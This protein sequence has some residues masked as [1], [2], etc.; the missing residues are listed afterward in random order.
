MN[1]RML[2]KECV[3]KYWDDIQTRMLPS[4]TQSYKSRLA[5][6]YNSPLANIKMAEFKGIKVVEWLNWLKQQPTAKNKSRKSF[7][8]DLDF[9]KA[10]LN[11]YKNFLNEDLMSLSPRSIGKCVFLNLLFQG[12]RII[13]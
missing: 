13:I 3:S 11:W 4:T 6:L 2:F 9:L 1:D 7:V 10:I 8:K 5:Y 12:D